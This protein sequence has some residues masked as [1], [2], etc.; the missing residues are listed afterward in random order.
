MATKT[1]VA[2]HLSYAGSAGYKAARARAEEEDENESGSEGVGRN[3]AEVIHSDA[4]DPDEFDDDVDDVIIQEAASG[5]R[6]VKHER[7]SRV[8]DTQSRRHGEDGGG[9]T[10]RPPRST[11]IILD[12]GD[13]LQEE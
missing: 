11:T 7:V 4:P 10:D 5:S 12:L 13:E 9:G 6:R 3:R 8:P 1:C 2:M